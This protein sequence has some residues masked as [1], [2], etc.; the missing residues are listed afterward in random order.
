MVPYSK[1]KTLILNDLLKR[2]LPT[3][4]YEL[5]SVNKDGIA[6]VKVRSTEEISAMFASFELEDVLNKNNIEYTQSD[7]IK[8][9]FRVSLSSIELDRATDYNEE[10]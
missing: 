7:D 9:K 1:Q 4:S 6:Y 3:G 8:I 2:S 5:V 10:G